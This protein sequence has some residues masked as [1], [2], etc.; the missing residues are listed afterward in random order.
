MKHADH[1]GSSTPAL[2]CSVTTCYAMGMPQ[3]TNA[4]TAQLAEHT[5]KAMARLEAAHRADLQDR[6]EDTDLILFTHEGL[7]T[8][9][10]RRHYR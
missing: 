3:R 5:A 1:T 8:H 2:A 7:Y 4:Y 10:D 6:G 9:A